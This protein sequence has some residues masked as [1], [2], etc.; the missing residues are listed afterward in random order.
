[1]LLQVVFKNRIMKK[2][3]VF[4]YL[5]FGLLILIGCEEPPLDRSFTPKQEISVIQV[6]GSRT[7]AVDPQ[8]DSGLE[9]APGVF[10][11]DEVTFSSSTNDSEV[12]ERRWFIPQ[13]DASETNNSPIKISPFNQIEPVTVSFKRAIN[14]NSDAESVGLPIVLFE[15][16]EN[17]ITNRLA[18]N[19]QVRNRVSAVIQANNTA[20]QGVP[21]KVSAGSIEQLGLV[22]NDLN[23]IGQTTL[24]WDFGNGT[25]INQ[26]GETESKIVTNDVKRNFD[27]TFNSAG[28]QTVSLKVQRNWPLKSESATTFTINVI[29]FLTPNGGDKDPVKISADGSKITIRY[30]QEIANISVAEPEDF[31]IIIDAPMGSA[32][33]SVSV[34][35]VGL[36]EGD[37]SNIELSLSTDIPGYLMDFVKVT[38]ENESKSDRLRTKNGATIG[39]LNNK[40]F[41]T[42]ENLLETISAASFEDSTVWTDGGFFFPKPAD[43]PE[44]SFSTER[45]LT[46]NSSFL[47]ETT[48]TDLE[49]IPNNFGIG[50]NIIEGG[51]FVTP[52]DESAEYILSMWVYVESTEPN[53]NIDF[54][55]LDFAVFTT[56]ATTSNL[57]IGEWVK[58]SGRRSIASDGDLRSLI[59]VVNATKNTTSNSKIFVDYAEIRIVDDGK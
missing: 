26:N 31:G 52:V 59:R 21:T 57:P 51:P 32:T 19:I 39:N 11:G 48:G 29:E 1:M 55:L 43:N 41:P 25:I 18:T 53:T 30:D 24:E 23:G 15:T 6:E 49:T 9:G 33:P 20:T 38:F 8:D 45:S 4:N 14:S 44:I 10:V 36:Q 46:G 40:A 27:V 37:E 22:P 56:G 28:E 16:L 5:I 17:G 54:F 2:S 42:G 7:P 58:I 47:F 13:P 34:T 3:L 12:I 50:A 35:S